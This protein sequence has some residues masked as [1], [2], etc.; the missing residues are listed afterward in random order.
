MLFPPLWILYILFL[1]A[2]IV[3]VINFKH[4]LKNFLSTQNFNL[5][6]TS[7]GPH[8]MLVNLQSE[9][10]LYYLT[11]RATVENWV[12]TVEKESCLCVCLAMCVHV[13]EYIE[14]HRLCH[15]LL[16][17]K[18][19]TVKPCGSCWGVNYI[20]PHPRKKTRLCTICNLSGV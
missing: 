4:E 10:D 13:C 18:L 17:S 2:V 6:H 3:L 1:L 7:I 11:V 19:Y 5:S 8:H 20:W 12:T 9:I 14:Q 16:P 15:L